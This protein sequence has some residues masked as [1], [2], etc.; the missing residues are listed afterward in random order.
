MGI[1]V[2]AT[3]MSEDYI[4]R[5]ACL[6]SCAWNIFVVHGLARWLG[7]ADV[8][9]AGQFVWPQCAKVWCTTSANGRRKGGL[10]KARFFCFP[11]WTPLWGIDS[12]ILMHAGGRLKQRKNRWGLFGLQCGM[13]MFMITAYQSARALPICVCSLSFKGRDVTWFNTETTVQS[14]SK[15][16][17]VL[18]NAWKWLALF[19]QVMLVEHVLILACC[20]LKLLQFKLN[21]WSAWTWV[22]R[23]FLVCLKVLKQQ[24]SPV[25]AV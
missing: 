14:L 11:A 19:K 3:W 4:G 24:S 18:V 7:W 23:L 12:K 10:E 16:L 2:Y 8:A 21:V 20:C 6:N 5:A 1:W 13:C 22:A 25:R 15:V 9:T 17:L